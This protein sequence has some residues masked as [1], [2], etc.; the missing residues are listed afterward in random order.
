MLTLDPMGEPCQ[1]K[2]YFSS[3][4]P[5]DGEHLGVLVPND[6]YFLIP[7]FKIYQCPFTVQ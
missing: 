2:V 4:D 6:K 3:G 5:L 7:F 1:H